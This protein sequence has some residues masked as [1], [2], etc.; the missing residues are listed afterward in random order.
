MR[1]FAGLG[2]PVPSLDRDDIDVCRLPG[3]LSSLQCAI[4]AL[5]NRVG[6]SSVSSVAVR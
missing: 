5:R 6:P 2:E 4:E 3:A 1:S